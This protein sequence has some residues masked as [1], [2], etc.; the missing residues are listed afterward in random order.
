MTHLDSALPDK[1]EH[2]NCVVMILPIDAPPP[3][4]YVKQ[5]VG[6][7]ICK[8]DNISWDSRPDYDKN[9]WKVCILFLSFSFF[10]FFFVLN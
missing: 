1:R 4:N 9:I 6:T 5:N 10:F 8:I 2:E 7:C 3:S